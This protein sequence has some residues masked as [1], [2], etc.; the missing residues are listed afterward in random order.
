MIP[1]FNDAG[2]RMPIVFNTTLRL[3]EPI[4]GNPLHIY[5][6][7]AVAVRDVFN[8]TMENRPTRDGSEAYGVRKSAK[9][10]RLDGVARA[11]TFAHLSDMN[12]AL[13]GWMDPARLSNDDPL[14]HGFAPLAF[15]VLSVAGAE[16]SY[17]LARPVQNPD[18]LVDQYL[19][20]NAPFRLEFV[21]ADPRRYLLAANIYTATGG[22]AGFV[23]TNAGNY[24]SI[25]SI[26]ITMSGAG[27]SGYQLNH[28]G[29]DPDGVVR[30]DLSGTSNGDIIRVYAD[31]QVV[32][33]N[34][35]RAD[36]LV[37]DTTNWNLI[38][39]PGN[40]SL[41]AANR[42]NA[43]TEWIIYHAFSM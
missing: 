21:C 20:K 8:G 3:N 39:L 18:Y 43:S 23:M 10:I 9:I 38:M 26:E 31:Q 2:E 11:P 35:D 5:E 6:V 28:L 24:P 33:L 12:A 25:P 32:T 16:E 34:G 4:D 15:D 27:H 13:R 22:V 14:G 42:T 36:H 41:N 19:G 17:V 7:N 1:I 30:L 37:H 29:H 40:A